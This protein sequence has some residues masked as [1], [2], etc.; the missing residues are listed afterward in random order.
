MNEFKSWEEI[1]WKK[2]ER[3]VRKLQNQ[4]FR[5]QERGQR[6]RVRWL[7]RMLMNSD[8]NLLVSIRKV[9]QKN[10]GKKT[11]GIDDVVALTNEDRLK[12][13]NELKEV[14]LKDYNPPPVKGVDIK[15][16]NGKIRPLGIP[17][18]KDRILQ[19]VVKN[20]L[21][22]QWEEMFEPTTYGFRQKRNT[23][24]ALA[25]TH[26][27]L[28]N[29]NRPYIF[30]GDFKSCF[31]NLDHDYILEQLKDFPE[32]ELIKRWLKAGCLKE[33]I[34]I[35]STKGTKQGNSISPLLAVIALQGMQEVLG[36]TYKEKQYKRDGEIKLCHATQGKY[37][38]S[39]F[40]DDFI[41]ACETKEDAKKIPELLESYLKERGLTL[42]AEKTKITSIY[43]GFDFLGF[44]VRGHKSAQNAKKP[45]KLIIKPSKESVIEAKRKIKQVF[46]DCRG[47]NVGY[48]I[49][50]LNPV[51]RGIANY[52]SNFCSKET[53]SE[54][55]EYVWLHTKHFLKHLHPKKNWKWLRERYFKPDYAGQSK[56]KWILTDPE[57][58]SHQLLKF[59]WTPIRY[60]RMIAY[61]NT[62]FDSRLTGYF[63]SRDEQEFDRNNIYTR[64]YLAKRQKYKCPICD[65][66]I[67][68]PEKDYDVHHDIPRVVGGSNNRKNLR[69]VH[70]SCHNEYHKVFKAK[71]G[72]PA[73]NN[74]KAFKTIYKQKLWGKNYARAGCLERDKSGS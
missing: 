59:S 56:N 26:Y 54:M 61:K 63:K 4:I 16:K 20:A 31:D 9:T 22:P 65:C 32:V 44:N 37:R 51:I 29:G 34:L 2:L 49:T 40:A 25:R 67:T 45:F 7:Q 28:K 35:E 3:Q 30:E 47:H 17:T 13:Y 43:D 14:K 42:Q 38:L 18:I 71:N 39:F 60:H 52:W 66:P 68:D 55:D 74:I 24:D 62:P 36:I 23:A 70:R 58:I 8:A 46:R 69:L 73:D 15:K 10:R 1:P 12:L 21:E 5:A 57:E 6:R 72:R 64:R 53:F 27:D 33:T 41:V 11:A 48:L 19:T 50:K